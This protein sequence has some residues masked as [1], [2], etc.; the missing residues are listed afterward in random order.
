MSVTAVE[1]V[2]ALADCRRVV[3]LFVELENRGRHNPRFS[4]TSLSQEAE[5]FDRSIS[6]APLPV[7]QMVM[8]RMREVVRLLVAGRAEAARHLAVEVAYELGMVN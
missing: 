8:E 1:R 4:Q 3:L 5:M 2:G 7:D 6:D